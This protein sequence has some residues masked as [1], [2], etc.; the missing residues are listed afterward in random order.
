MTYILAYYWYWCIKGLNDLTESFVRNFTVLFLIL[1][2]DY[3]EIA[4]KNFS[5]CDFFSPKKILSLD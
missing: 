2:T 1:E 3:F 4:V 5:S